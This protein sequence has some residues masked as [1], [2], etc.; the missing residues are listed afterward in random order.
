VTIRGH[1]SLRLVPRMRDGPSFDL[2]AD[3]P[4]GSGPPRPINRSMT[5]DPRLRSPRLGGTGHWPFPDAG[6]LQHAGYRSV[7]G[8]ASS[9][10]REER[11]G[12]RVGARTPTSPPAMVARIV[13]NESG[14]ATPL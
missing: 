3:A 12:P 9:L 2:V 4:G 11:A 14:T 5:S 6:R 8:P 7:V 1:P 13:V 10:G